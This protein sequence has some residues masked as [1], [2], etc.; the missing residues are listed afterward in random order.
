MI[1][2]GTPSYILSRNN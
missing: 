2:I 1:R